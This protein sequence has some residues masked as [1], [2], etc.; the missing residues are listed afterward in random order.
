MKGGLLAAMK[1]GGDGVMFQS[2]SYL[3]LPANEAP[4]ITSKPTTALLTTH[5]NPHSHFIHLLSS[6]SQHHQL[7]LNLI[8]TILP[9]LN[10]HL[11]NISIP[12]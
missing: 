3:D 7:L 4:R 1:S 11:S 5:S 12:T 9:K 8:N 10:T 2:L 6:S